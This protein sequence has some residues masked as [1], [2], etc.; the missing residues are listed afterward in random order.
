VRWFLGAD[1]VGPGYCK[2]VCERDFCVPTTRCKDCPEPDLLPEV[3][4]TVNL[5]LACLTQRRTA[6]MGGCLGFDYAG[7]R[8]AAQMMQI[9]DVAQSFEWLRVMEQEMIAVLNDGQED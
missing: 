4:E 9:D 1:E 5:F 7:V 6:M 2:T 3:I 8:A